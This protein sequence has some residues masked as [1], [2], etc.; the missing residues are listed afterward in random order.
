MGGVY[1]CPLWPWRLWVAFM[2]DACEQSL[3][4]ALAEAL[5]VEW[6]A[7]SVEAGVEMPGER[8]PNPAEFARGHLPTVDPKTLDPKALDPKTEDSIT[9][10]P[11]TEDSVSE[12]SVAKGKGSNTPAEVGGRVRPH[13]GAVATWMGLTKTGRGA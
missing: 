13:T 4:T 8:Y 12:G 6:I 11:K 7:W 9:V 3:C 5:G 10:D 2:D 1:V